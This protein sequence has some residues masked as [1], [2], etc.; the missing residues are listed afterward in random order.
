MFSA[1]LFLFSGC[2]AV[3]DMFRTK[4]ARL[5]ADNQQLDRILIP[6]AIAAAVVGMMVM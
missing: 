1:C 5:A 3:H 6:V 4:S 2:V